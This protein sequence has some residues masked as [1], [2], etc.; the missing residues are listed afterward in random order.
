M[1]TNTFRIYNKEFGSS[2]EFMQTKQLL[3]WGKGICEWNYIYP[4]LR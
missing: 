3:A 1:F 2:R 4:Y